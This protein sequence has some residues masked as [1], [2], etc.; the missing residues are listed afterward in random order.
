MATR[1]PDAV[2]YHLYWLGD[3]RKTKDIAQ[4]LLDHR[5]AIWHVAQFINSNEI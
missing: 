5:G 4:R 3:G 2:S 1:K